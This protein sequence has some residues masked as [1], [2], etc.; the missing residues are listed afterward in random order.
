[1]ANGEITVGQDGLYKDGVKIKLEFGNLEQIAAIRKYEKRCAALKEGISPTISY[2]IEAS[3]RF[4]CLCGLYNGVD[5][6]EA[7][8]ENDEL[9]FEGLTTHCRGC[10]QKYKFVV[11][12]EYG[13]SASGRRYIKNETL[14][15]KLYNNEI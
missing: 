5:D 9:C 12:R 11:E 3:A 6:I 8:S 13:V 14:L 1:M 7:D 10:K 2:S 4:T 15:V